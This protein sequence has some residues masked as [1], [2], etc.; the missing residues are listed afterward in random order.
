MTG[1]G[2]RPH[3]EG[4]KRRAAPRSVEGDKRIQ[5]ERHVIALDLQIAFIHVRGERERIQFF[6]VQLR[7]RRIVDDLSVLFVAGTQNVFGAGDTTTFLTQS[8]GQ[9]IL[10][11]GNTMAVYITSP[12]SVSINDIGTTIGITVFTA[13]AM[14]Y[15]E[16]NV[17]TTTVTI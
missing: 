4:A 13:Q 5:E 16:T 11:S 7:T 3:A 1:K 8:T 17:R 12:T 9:L 2:L 14:Y 10:K 6:R 15:Q